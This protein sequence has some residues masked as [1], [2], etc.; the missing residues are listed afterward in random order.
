MRPSPLRGASLS[1]LPGVAGRVP[2]GAACVGAGVQRVSCVLGVSVGECVLR[3]GRVGVGVSSL[4]A[5]AGFASA[6]D[7]G[8]AERSP[9]PE[10]AGTPPPST[11]TGI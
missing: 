1:G 4:L 6:A 11:H 3:D 8:S 5:A 2:V 7:P 9:V 10:P